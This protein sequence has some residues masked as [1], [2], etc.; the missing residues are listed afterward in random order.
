[1]APVAAFF[2]ATVAFFKAAAAAFS[3]L[4]ALTQLAVVTALQFAGQYVSGKLRGRG[5]PVD[6]GKI[7]VRIP[8]ATRWLNAGECRQGGA[9][10]FGEFDSIGH[11]WYVVVHSD[12]LM[13]GV[14]IQHFMDDRK[15]NIDGVGDV[16]HPE[17]GL[18]GD[19]PVTTITSGFYPHFRVWTT[20]YTASNPTPPGITALR[21]ALGSRWTANHLLVGTTYSVVR[22]HNIKLENRAKVYKWRGPF[23]LGEPALSIAARWSRVHDPRDSSQILGDATTYKFSKNPV[24]IWAWFRTHPFGRNKSID[25]INWT[26]VGEEATK[27]DQII[28]GIQGSQPRYECHATI[29]EDKERVLAEQEILVTCDAI[30]I[31][32]EDGKCWPKVGVYEAPT[33]A[34]TRN[35]D[36][37]AMESIDSTNIEDQKQGV[38]V[39]Y[40]DPDSD[41]TVQPSAPWYN[42]ELYV[43]GEAASF[44]TVDVEF[45]Q[46]HNQAMRLAKIIG[47]RSQSATRI[48]PTVG[49]RGL[50]ARTERNVNI[51]YDN[52][53][54][55]EYEIVTNVELDQSGTYC[56]FAA[57]PIDNERFILTAG[58]ERAKPGT[59][60]VNPTYVPPTQPGINDFRF[61]LSRLKVTALPNANAD[62]QQEF[63]Y[64][65]TDEIASGNWEKM[66]V[67]DDGTE[68]VS[69]VLDDNREYTMR[70]R[71]LS[72]GGTTS[73]WQIHG[74]TANTELPPAV[75]GFDLAQLQ[76]DISDL[77]SLD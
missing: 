18:D 75:S 27:C 40:M 47:M 66:T 55:G 49:L 13:D 1:M 43:A 35:R 7:N 20:T 29:P 4:S 67:N 28:T 26:K 22:C 57:V 5:S 70:S 15:V 11:F 21:Q 46:N 74:T 39:R 19:D 53:F 63:E 10:V 23:T 9:A 16:I 17:F 48:G 34:L 38:I 65:P 58:E 51:N 59:V 56:A 77:Q 36:I 12:S 30:L 2:A 60:I 45:C 64:I 33:L 32:D 3:A 41:Y 14:P 76:S 73:G 54:A 42:P 24:L 44:L 50:R 6:G 61:G 72:S 31:F 68:A 25:E 71:S 52:T 69:P 8:E 37:V 62:V